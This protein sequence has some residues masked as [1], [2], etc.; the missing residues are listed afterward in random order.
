[1]MNH[2]A[3]I[4]HPEDYSAQTTASYAGQSTPHHA[5]DADRHLTKLGVYLQQRSVNK[6]TVARKTGLSKQ[7]M[8]E[9][10]LNEDAKLRAREVYLIALAVGVSPCE[11][12]EYVCSDLKLKEDA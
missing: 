6:A 3:E 4:R 10:T 2:P 9:L 7:R 11:L 8:G 12:F 5:L 1:M